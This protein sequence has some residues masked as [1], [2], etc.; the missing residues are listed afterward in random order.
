[1]PTIGAAIVLCAD[2]YALAPG[3]SRAILQLIAARRLSATSCMSASRFWPQHAAW[4]RPLA[5]RIDVGL[6]LTLTDLPPLTGTGPLAR[7]GRLPSLRRLMRQAL[8]GQLPAQ[9]L[10]RELDAQLDAFA[11]AWGGP[12]DFLD[13]HQHVH[14]LPGVWP[15]VL[16]LWRERLEGSGSWLRVG[17]EPPARILRRRV[18]IVRA[19]VIGALALPLRRAADR[20]GIPANRGFSGVNDFGTGIPFSTLMERFVAGLSEGAL[21]MCHPGFVDETLIA[22]DP[23]TVRREQEYVYLAGDEFPRLLA[24]RGL[25]L[26][27]LAETR[28]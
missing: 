12:P 24:R 5:G 27:R 23:V 26:G 25:R 22:S 15:V 2:D 1:M 13:G 4:L 7:E 18:A 19:L 21:V 11:A 6:H 3:V 9:A 17:V 8:L 14:Q 16:D 20:R 28:I 10:R